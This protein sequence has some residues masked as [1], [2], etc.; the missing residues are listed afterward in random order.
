MKLHRGGHRA[1]RRI[2]VRARALAVLIAAFTVVV[3][4]AQALHLALVSHH[5]CEVHGQIE[6]GDHEAPAEVAEDAAPGG[7]SI[8]PLGEE[9]HDCEGLAVE[10]AVAR[11][12]QPFAAFVA[13]GIVARDR[14]PVAVERAR[15][16]WQLAPKNS[17]PV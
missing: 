7:V 9:H 2:A 3:S 11:E 14:A 6:H 10:A 5:L 16:L 1:T 13:H 17:P 4:T 15:P 8:G 12:P